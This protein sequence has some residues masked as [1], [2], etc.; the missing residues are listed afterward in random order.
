MSEEFKRLGKVRQRIVVGKIAKLYE[1]GLPMG[2]I[3]KTTKFD[4]RLVNEVI[5]MI[6][7][8]KQLKEE[9]KKA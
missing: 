2:E 4:E 3:I 9:S 7:K 5:Y 1:Q 6:V 8:A